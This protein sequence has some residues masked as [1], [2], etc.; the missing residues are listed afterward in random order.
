MDVASDSDGASSY[1][2]SSDGSALSD[3]QTGE[4]PIQDAIAPLP[5]GHGRPW[6]AES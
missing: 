1:S 2:N 3:L 5:G 6:A 4:L